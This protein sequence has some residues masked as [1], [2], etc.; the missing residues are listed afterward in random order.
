[1]ISIHSLA[2]RGSSESR[3]S[4]RVDSQ[5]R[6]IVC[7]DRER[8][9][10][11]R[12]DSGTYDLNPSERS[13]VVMPLFHVH[14]RVIEPSFVAFICA[15][16]FCDFLVLSLPVHEFPSISLVSSLRV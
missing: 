8:I 5:Y 12:V 2:D 1:M 13:F 4:V 11:C 10:V 15:L 9:I 16:Q 7:N 6:V 3:K 14:V